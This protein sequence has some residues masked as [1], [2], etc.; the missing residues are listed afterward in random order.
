MKK[1]IKHDKGKPRMDLIDP[2]GEI[3]EAKAMG[4]GANKYHDFNYLSGE[5]LQWGQ[6][7]AACRRHLNAWKR[8]EDLD[9]ESGLPH[10]YHAKACI[11]ML[12]GLIE[13]GKGL[14]NRFKNDNKR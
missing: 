10:L 7:Y 4:H 14:D 8:G 12:I 3:G 13:R 1:A 6:L 5:G 2:Y 11:G 9:K